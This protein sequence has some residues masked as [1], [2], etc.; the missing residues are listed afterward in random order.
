MDE[1]HTG[2]NLAHEVF[3]ITDRYGLI[4]FLCFLNDLFKVLTAKLKNQIL[5]LFALLVLGVINVQ[6]LN[7]VFAGPQLL[8]DFKL[9]RHVLPC[10]GGALN[11]HSALRNTVIRL[12]NIA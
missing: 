4:D 2:K 8:K 3:D 6:Q 9:T 5:N 12:K 7:A 11:C 10:L 1:S